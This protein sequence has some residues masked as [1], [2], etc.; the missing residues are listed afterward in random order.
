[1]PAQPL[2]PSALP[3]LPAL[4]VRCTTY[5]SYVFTGV[6]A[7]RL[8]G[9]YCTVPW[10]GTGRRRPC[11][12]YSGAAFHLAQSPLARGQLHRAASHSATFSS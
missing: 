10:K 8:L 1:M 6:G 7:A 4:P 2:C 9:E 5:A 11:V 3:L 12:R